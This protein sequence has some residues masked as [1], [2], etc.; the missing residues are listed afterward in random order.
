MT[1]GC[2]ILIVIDPEWVEVSDAGV[3]PF[4]NRVSLNQGDKSAGSASDPTVLT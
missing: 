1:T 4:R 2:R 3:E